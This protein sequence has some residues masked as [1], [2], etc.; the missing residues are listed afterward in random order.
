MKVWWYSKLNHPIPELFIND[1]QIKV[2]NLI[3]Y[4]GDVFNDK[5]T[6]NDLMMDRVSRGTKC[7]V[8][9]EAFMRE[10]SFGIFTVSIYVLL[11][12]MI[13]VSS[14]L[15]NCQAWSNVSDKDIASLSR[16][17]LKVLRNILRARKMTSSSFLFLELG[18]LPIKYEIHIRQLSFL[19]H[20]IHMNEEDPVKQVW[21]NLCLLPTY[22]NWWS[23]IKDLLECYSIDLME[24]YIAN[25]SEDAFKTRV[26]ESVRRYAYEILKTDCASKSK[27]KDLSY[28]KFELQQYLK[29]L[30]PKIAQTICQAR[31]KTLE[32]KAHTPFLFN[33]QLCRL[34]GLV[35]ESL[36]HILN[37]HQNF[38]MEVDDVLHSSNNFPLLIRIADSILNFY[39]SIPDGN[40]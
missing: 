26:K 23:D 33:S 35:D 10:T 17:Q 37:C 11:H 32:I 38:G 25:M 5:G 19:H 27:T 40:E 28:P 18:V 21:R 4:L 1:N 13:F 30:P 12:N 9:M 2:V 15:F 8:G 3:T 7:L 6:N 29:V 31:S 22:K 16:L 36:N 24:E 34:C 14:V 39:D 20:I